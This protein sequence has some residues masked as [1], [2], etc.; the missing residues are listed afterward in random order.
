MSVRLAALAALVAVSAIAWP[1]HAADRLSLDE[2]FARVAQ[3]HPD[4]RLFGARQDI[5]S[6]DLERA[7]LRPAWVAGASV[8]NAFGTGEASGLDGAELT[9][10]LASVLER[11]GKLDARRTLAQSR[12]DALAVEREARRLDLLAEVARRYLAM[13]AAQRQRDIAELDIA[14]RQRTVA[15]ARHRLQAGASPES[16]V[17]TAQAALARAE[18]DRARAEQRFAAA[19]Q[20]LAA[21]WGERAPTFDVVAA[22]PTALPQVA[23]FA[24]LTSTLEQTPELAQFVGERRIREARLQL[25]RAD[26]KADLDW[27]VGVRRLQATDDMALI[28]SIS[29]PLG[30]SR[31]AQPEIR[32]AEADLTALEI[33][34]E[35]KGLSLYSTLAEAHGRYLTARLEVDR[36]RTDV[37]PK[38]AKAE[39]AAERAYRAGAISYLE[40]AQLQSERTAAR[41]Q[42]LDAA[43]EAQRALIEIQRLTGAPFVAAPAQ[44]TQGGTP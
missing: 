15:G 20:H 42:Q 22:D 23:S 38:L 31:R 9:L 7:A 39:A 44:A 29:M 10:S 35:S 5:L 6:A 33:E 19:R 8:E 1:A 17:L 36:L 37:L 27:E 24:Q 30:A 12:I 13:V 21:L 18:L 32:A 11:G 2:A 14:Q 43:L 40:W 26:A 34:R 16:V 28:G 3:T 4:L 25:A 41:K